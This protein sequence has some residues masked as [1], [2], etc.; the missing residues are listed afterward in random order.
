MAQT[1][2]S[3][4]AQRVLPDSNSVSHQILCLFIALQSARTL[5]SVDLSRIQS[6]KMTHLVQEAGQRVGQPITETD[7]E[8]VVGGDDDLVYD[9]LA[10]TLTMSELILDLKAHLVIAEE[11]AFL[12]SDNPVFKYNKYCEGFPGG[13]PTG[14][15]KKG[16][17]LFIPI[18]PSLYLILYDGS[19]YKSDSR[20]SISRMTR[21]R[22]QDIDALNSIQIASAQNN[23]YFSDWSRRDYIRD[24]TSRF[25][26]IRIP[27]PTVVEEFVSEDTP[28]ESMIHTYEKMPNLSLSLSFLRIKKRALRFPLSDRWRLVRVAHKHLHRPE[29]TRPEFRKHITRYSRPRRQRK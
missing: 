3:L 14:A 27:D 4:R 13:G 7:V 16:L 1:L 9:V 23:I 29:P 28:F 5:R 26:E 21:A 12:T 18:S 22:T 6:T 10:N 15:I 19:I 8:K 20:D 17:Q 11:D 2:S 24:L 25:S